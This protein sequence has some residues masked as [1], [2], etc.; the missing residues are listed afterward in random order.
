MNKH[1]QMMVSLAVVLAV[2]CGMVG[3]VIDI[4]VLYVNRIQLQKAVDA[5]VL[6]GAQ[7]LPD[8][9][10]WA[11]DMAKFYA[12]TNGRSGDVVNVEV[13]NANKT[14]RAIGTRD[15]DLFFAQL[16]GL[17]T[18]AVSAKARANIGVIVGY[19]GVVPFGLQQKTLTYGVE[20]ILKVGGGA[21]NT[22]NFGALSLSGKGANAYRDDIE[23][24][25]QSPLKIGDWVST[26]PGNMSGP[27]SQGVNYRISQDPNATFTTV[28]ENSPRIIVVPVI[29]G[30][31]Q[32]RDDV[33]IVGFAAFFLEGVGG[34]GKDNYVKGVFMRQ[35]VA[36]EI[37]TGTDFGVFGAKLAPY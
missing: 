10:S 7:E 15:V 21:G 11:I 14:I 6:A 16:F 31:P 22:G 4:G 5:G 20:Y 26:K 19:T 12:N 2:L 24:G 27:T 28:Q 3:L 1:G 37:G 30:D 29:I 18:A 33:Q 17:N 13:L 32:G 9:A 25:Y 34:S 35:V 36:G 23:L 8:D